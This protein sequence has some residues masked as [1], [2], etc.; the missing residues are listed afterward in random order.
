MLNYLNTEKMMGHPISQEDVAASF[1]QAVVDVLV[2]KTMNAAKEMGVRRV[3][4]AGGVSANL[5]LR[6]TLKERCDKAGLDFSRPDMI[7]CTDN[8]DMIASAAYYA[9]QKGEES[10]LCLNAYPNLKL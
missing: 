3:A 10:P 6:T 5:L 7:L 2:E 8:A 4:A 9:Y 1:Q